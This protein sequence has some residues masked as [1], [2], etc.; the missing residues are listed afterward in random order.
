MRARWN[1]S[2][3]IDKVRRS[4]GTPLPPELL[5]LGGITSVQ[6]GAAVA[7]TLFDRAGPA[8]VV[9][10]RLTISAIVLTLAMRPRLRGRTR[11]DLR[12]VVAYGL[13]LGTMNWSFYEALNRLPLGVAV[14][15]EF[16]GPLTVA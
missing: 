8:G 7:N 13:I 14:T 16:V 12:A 11:A 1:G 10:L 9:F 3:R 2:E 6:F 5:V 15:I 4:S